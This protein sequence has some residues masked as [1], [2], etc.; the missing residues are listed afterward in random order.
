MTCHDIA[1]Q[2]S[3]RHGRRSAAYAAQQGVR[4]GMNGGS[5]QV[6]QEATTTLQTATSQ[7]AA[8]AECSHCIDERDRLRSALNACD[9]TDEHLLKRLRRVEA[10]IA[11]MRAIHTQLLADLAS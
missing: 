2:L 9:W 3:T 8:E 6:R 10:A 1:R 5:S 4:G 11:L 7:L